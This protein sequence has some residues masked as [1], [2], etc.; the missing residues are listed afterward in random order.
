MMFE[1]GLE[2]GHRA[3][4]SQEVFSQV[5]VSASA[6]LHHGLSLSLSP[7]QATANRREYTHGLLIIATA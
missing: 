1:S 2:T 4:G 3:Y 7:L 5:L 6:D